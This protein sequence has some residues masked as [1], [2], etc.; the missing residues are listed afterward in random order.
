MILYGIP[1]CSTVKKTRAWLAAQSLSYTFHDFKRDGLPQA[2]L[3][4][5]MA[6]HGWEAVLNR[7]GQ[8]WRNFSDAQ[9]ASV[10]DAATARVLMAANPSVIKRPILDHEGSITLGFSEAA[11]ATLFGR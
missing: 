4:H 7:K 2:A 8:A 10:V 3:Q 9:C 1:N 5:W 11:Y 6:V